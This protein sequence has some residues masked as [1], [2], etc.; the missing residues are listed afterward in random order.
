LK[1]EGEISDA[2]TFLPGYPDGSFGWA[3]VRAYLPNAA[4]MP[5]L[6]VEY[7]GMGDSD[8]PKDYAY[9]T[10]ERTDLVE[11]L[12]RDLSVQSTTLVAFDFSSLV[13]LEHLRRQLERAERGQ[14]V[15]GPA[16]R[17]VV[18]FNGGLFTDGHSHPWYTTP[19]LRRFPKR[20]WRGL[21]RSFTLFK[22]TAGV[23][24]SKGYQ[25]TDAE[26]R[27]LQ[28]TMS[29]RDGLFYLAAAAGFAADHKAQGDRLDFGRL[30]KTYREQFPF[31]V[32]GS[33]EDPF[34]YRQIDLAEERL[35]K[36]GLQI[37]R[38]PGGHL[39]TNEQP[40]ALAALIAKF[41]RGL[42]RMQPAPG[43]REQASHHDRRN[44][45]DETTP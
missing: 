2:V 25:V 12:W 3:K 8:K 7:V 38:L 13:V 14:P 35:G 27:E 5:K 42:A 22:M 10:T 44:E 34:E 11:A 20:A 31:L 6:F 32:G 28:N 1:R 39:S 4:E 15:G 43:N 26:V 19:I 18:I 30:F 33:N 9:S 40:E 37:E 29:R 17:G 45:N 21:G 23:M 41:E 24:W 36:L 16:I